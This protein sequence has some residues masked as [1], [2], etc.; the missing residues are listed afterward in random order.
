MKTGPGNITPQYITDMMQRYRDT[1]REIDIHLKKWDNE[2][3][4]IHQ[5]IREL[6]DECPHE[7]K[8]YSSEFMLDEAYCIYC[9][10]TENYQ[11]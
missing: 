1:F 7:F 4:K 8:R 10:K 5:K 6:Q 9:G 11:P 2:A 3:K